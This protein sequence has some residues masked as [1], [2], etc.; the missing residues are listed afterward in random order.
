MQCMGNSG[1]IRAKSPLESLEPKNGRKS[2]EKGVGYGYSFCCPYI[3]GS[4]YC[5]GNPLSHTSLTK[6]LNLL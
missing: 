4:S 1:T 6:T 3:V 5:L 2:R